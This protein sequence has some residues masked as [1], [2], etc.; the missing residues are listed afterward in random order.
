LINPTILQSLKKK[1][2]ERRLPFQLICVGW[3]QLNT[4]KGK[5][6]RE[7]KGC[8]A[9]IQI[10]RR[11][12]IAVTRGSGKRI[13]IGGGEI[14]INPNGRLKSHLPG[15]V[16]KTQPANMREVACLTHSK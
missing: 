10:I 15:T 13:K 7:D 14:K 2:E 11:C 9:V 4:K 3:D 16:W 1:G 12:N 8:G 6:L 5:S